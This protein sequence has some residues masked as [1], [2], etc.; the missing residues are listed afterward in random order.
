M[1]RAARQQSI[2]PSSLRETE[3]SGAMV[4]LCSQ[5]DGG[6]LSTEG[7]KTTVAIALSS[8]SLRI[9]ATPARAHVGS[10][11]W[12]FEP[13]QCNAWTANAVRV[14]CVRVIESFGK[15]VILPLRECGQR[16]AQTSS[17]RR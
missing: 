6:S 5:K 14:H 8:S 17:A 2:V 15:I 10:G 7:N 11:R 9:E 1:N 12:S 3:S 4:T 16:C 13:A